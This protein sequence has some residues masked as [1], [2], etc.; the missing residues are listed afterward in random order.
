MDYLQKQIKLNYPSNK[1]KISYT[2][3]QISEN[4]ATFLKKEFQDSKFTLPSG[5]MNACI[6]NLYCHKI[7]QCHQVTFNIVHTADSKNIPPYGLLQRIIKRI[8]CILR[9]FSITKNF[10][11]W[12]LPIVYVRKFPLN[13]QLISP[14]HINGGYT[15]HN[16]ETI[17]IYR[18]EECTK[19]ILHE[20]LHHSKYD[21]QMLWNLNESQ[22]YLKEL[23]EI[24]HI[25]NITNLYINEAVVEC[26]AILMQ[27]LLIS[28]EFSIPLQKLITIETEWSLQQS[29]KVL[30]YQNT[31]ESLNM[32]KEN[33][34]A[35]AYIVIKSIFLVHI[36]D[37]LSLKS[38]NPLEIRNFLI[39]NK[40]LPL[41]KI[42]PKIIEDSSLRMTV[43]GDL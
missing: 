16:G 43:F 33:T 6:D 12:F 20:I 18:L 36:N 17:F 2:D 13:G 15:Y 22:L 9:I 41:P 24:F 40:T 34:N 39:K 25:D 28:F 4:V 23:K 7:L 11:I 26:F 37:F 31:Y 19:V 30:S 35:F 3:Q 27:I 21:N 14:E 29:Y 5:I 38:Y 10:T 32:W 42:I 8:V 1:F